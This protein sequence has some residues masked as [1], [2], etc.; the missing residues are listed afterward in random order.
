M[1]TDENM[2]DAV[3]WIGITYMKYNDNQV[4]GF[5]LQMHKSVGEQNDRGT[6]S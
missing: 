2:T 1:K 3:I 5:V 6:A 4:C